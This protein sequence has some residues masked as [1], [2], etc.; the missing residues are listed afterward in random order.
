MEGPRVTGAL[1]NYMV[2]RAAS[3]SGD[4]PVSSSRTDFH[5][6]MRQL[7]PSLV[8]FAACSAPTP[9]PIAAVSSQT[10][11]PLGD[12]HVSTAPRLGYVYSCQTSFG[13]G[14][15]RGGPG[16]GRGGPGPQRA[17]SD[18][19]WIHGSTWDPALKSTVSGDVT[20]PNSR[21]T[22]VREGDRRIVRA[23]NLPSHPTGV[24]PIAATDSASR[25]D[26]NPN[27]IREQ[28]ILLSL[29]A[30]P[31]SRDTAVCVPMGMIGFAL[32]GAAIFNALDAQG[33]DAPAHEVQDK[34]GGHPE[35][36]GQ[37]HYHDW[38]NCLVDSAG[39]AGRH[40]SLVGYAIDGFGIFGLFG[41]GGRRL[42]NADLD[43]CHG[44]THD[45]QW[46]GRTV[47]MYHYHMTAEYPYTIGC[48]RGQP[49]ASRGGPR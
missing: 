48:L 27:S 40:S 18:G 6:R 7:I 12:G 33:R 46:D 34:C 31:T 26:R 11:L 39:R 5:L 16:P 1:L 47:R 37:Y 42:T 24:F 41:D 32:S 45:I 35:M 28:N 49:I 17:F 23:N 15:G 44:H 19:P 36:R 8:L 43:E 22:V 10:L 13:R 14:R 30:A 3:G 25:Y 9:S 38:S 20:W 29:P 21:I 2:V 4:P